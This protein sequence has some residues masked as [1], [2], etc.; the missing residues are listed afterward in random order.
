DD[1]RG[2]DTARIKAKALEAGLIGESEI[3]AKS[4]AEI[5]NLIFA[6]GFS[7]ALEITSISGRGVGMDIVRNNIEK[8]G[9]TVDVKSAPG[10]GTTFVIK[11][12]LTLAIVAALIVEIAGE[13]FA[14]PQL[15]VL[16]LVRIERINSAPVLRL[17]RKLLPLIDVKK[18]LQLATGDGANGFV[19]V[20]QA[21]GQ[22]FGAIVDNVFHTEEIVIKPMSSKLR[23]IAIF[24][25][26]TILGD[27]S[28]ILIVDPNVLAQSLGRAAPSP[29]EASTDTAEREPK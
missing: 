14:F 1:G 20:I 3:S 21:G 29:S 18:A 6:P 26:M 24:S 17:R 16:E 8:F 19:V 13:R 23:H 9:G 27:G 2:L 22:I 15:S 28:V 5:N 7:T 4:H 25:G 11:I 10:S 12:P